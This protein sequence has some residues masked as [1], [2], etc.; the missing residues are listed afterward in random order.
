MRADPAQFQAGVTAE[1][2]VSH[3]ARIDAPASSRQRSKL[4]AL[5][6]GDLAPAALG[7]EAVTAIL[8]HAPGNGEPLGCIKVVAQNCWFSARPSGTENI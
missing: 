2:G 5:A 1:L 6:A 7:G 4:A 8:D 3:N